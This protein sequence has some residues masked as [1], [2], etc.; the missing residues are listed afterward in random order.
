MILSLDENP[1]CE[2]M[3]D[4]RYKT[5]GPPRKISH[6]KIYD[7]DPEGVL[8]QVTGWSD[9]AEAPTCPVYAQKIEDSGDGEAILIFG[10]PWGLRLKPTNPEEWSLNNPRQWGEPFLILDSTEDLTFVD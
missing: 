7:E 1:N 8:C 3:D 10:G 4:R 9:Q 6:I 5:I 2:G